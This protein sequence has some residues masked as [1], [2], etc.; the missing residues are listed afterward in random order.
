MP[1]I[2]AATLGPILEKLSKM[3]S[4]LNCFIDA[5]WKQNRALD[6]WSLAIILETAELIESYPWKWWKNVKAPIDMQN[7]R[8][9]LVDI[10]HFALSGAAQAA[11]AEPAEGDDA[12]AATAAITSGTPEAIRIYREILR[13]A[14]AK[15]FGLVLRKVFAIAAHYDFNII[16]YYVAKHT[17][18]H[19][20]QLGGYKKNAYQKVNGEG[21]E[22]NEML[23]A[24]IADITPAAI[25]ADFN[26]VADGILTKVYDVFAIDGA[27]RKTIEKW[28]H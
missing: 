7:V 19:V 16:A 17:L 14:D 23:H 11:A 28:M 13:D 1:T 18:N 2:D 9:E 12:L 8:I 25:L 24:C 21:M 27:S 5:D 6:D 26:G 22:D 20:R 10:L 4:A 15:R 3:Q